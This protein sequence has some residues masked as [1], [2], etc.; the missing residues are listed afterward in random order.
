MK[1]PEH[2]PRQFHFVPEERLELSRLAT[3]DFESCVSTIPPLR[4]VWVF[5]LLR[6][7]LQFA[8]LKIDEVI[9]LKGRIGHE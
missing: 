3:H 6:A 7:K 5:Y 8:S 4:L 2:K 1:L 9:H